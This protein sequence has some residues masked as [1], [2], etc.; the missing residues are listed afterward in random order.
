M[1]TIARDSGAG[2]YSKGWAGVGGAVVMAG[3]SVDRHVVGAGV[4]AGAELLPLEQEV[5]QQAGGAEAEPVG[6]EPVGPRRLV[7]HD[8]VLHGVLRRLDAAGGLD[9]DLPAGGG[10]EV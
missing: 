9:A 1:S 3:P 6:R 7:H 5:V 10:A 2:A 8:Q 4:V